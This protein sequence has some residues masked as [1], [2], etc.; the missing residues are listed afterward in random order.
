MMRHLA[1][2]LVT[3]TLARGETVVHVAP[4]GDDRAPGTL[5]RPFATLARARDAVRG[6][7]PARVVLR[8]GRH[9]LREPLVLGPDDG[10]VTYEAHP[11]EV[12]TV[13]GGT[14]LKDWKVEAGRW[15]TT[16]AGPRT[17]RFLS[18]DGARLG[19][20][21]VPRA[22]FFHVADFERQGDYR[23]STDA[24]RF[25][26]GQLDARWH[27]FAAV[28]LVVLHYWVDEHVRPTA[29]DDGVA[30]VEPPLTFKLDEG[31]GHPGPARFYAENVR[32]A[33]SEPGDW[34][35]DRASGELTL[36]PR[37]G[38][39]PARTEI[40]VP[41]LAELVRVEGRPEEGRHVERVAFRGVRFADADLAS[42]VMPVG[43][44]EQAASWVP[45]AVRFR[46]A[47][48]CIIE[49]CAFANLGT[50][51][52]ELG[53]ACF[54]NRVVR[55]QMHHLGAGGV[56]LGGVGDGGPDE[57]EAGRTEISENHIWAIGLSNHAAVGVLVQSAFGTRIARNH[58][59][60]T[61]YTAVSVG[62]SWEYGPN[63]SRDNVV[64]DN[65]LHDLGQGVLSDLGGIYTLGVQPGTVLRG[66]RIHDVR[67]ASY[68]GWGI[69]LDASSSHIL[70]ERND[71]TRTTGGSFHLHFGRDNLV[72]HN[73]FGDADGPVLD[74]TRPEP[75]LAV[76]FEGNEVW[77]APG[78]PLTGGRWEPGQYRT[79]GEKYRGGGDK[80][81]AGKDFAA[82]RAGGADEGSTHAP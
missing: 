79:R 37:A 46:G 48:H 58:I 45:G 7:Q 69:Y 75:H 35:C 25:A 51:A 55:N 64:E 77:N 52:V 11:G 24:L 56:K 78:K 39:D 38:D 21:R 30:R 82:W 54:D 43:A 65:Y 19:R 32:E 53:D 6:R 2:L 60:D 31:F 68:G 57:L 26:P 5:D 41:R 8:G 13:S 72:R 81:F 40:V 3:A 47:R 12:P 16:V 74:R 44:V 76:T 29:I 80:P 50:Y 1:A 49:A 42:G 63:P 14:L 22:G 33:V 18:A 73:R 67:A 62:W 36:V 71:V 20:T 27:D 70:V 9:E 61:R 66:N 10:D 4:T 28:E 17:F 15:T 59:H 23:Q 34:Y